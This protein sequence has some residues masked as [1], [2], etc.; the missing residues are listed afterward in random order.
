[1]SSYNY[2]IDNSCNKINYVSFGYDCSPAAT[3]RNLGIR[4]F[5]LPFD[6]VESKLEYI[7]NCIED[8]F[9]NF[10]CNL[11]LN[12]TETRVIDKY[13][14]EFPHDYPF[15]KDFCEEKLGDGVFGEDLQKKIIKN[16]NNYYDIVIKKYKRRIE[17]FN[18]IFNDTKPIIIL[19]RGYSVKNIK[20]F[21]Y[22]LTNKYKKG[23]IY[24]VVSSNEKFKNNMI[25]TCNTEK[26]G[27]WNEDVLWN[28][29]IQE[30][31]ISNK[32]L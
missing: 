22:Y 10:H 20:K 28:K 7:Y 30:I 25:I 27:K 29:A 31:I 26:N 1:M 15:S 16:W 18:H 23:N 21:G 4:D 5:A 13:G 14:F 32:L 24:F 2:E 17:R 9:N 11:K 6:W 12:K 19:C 8:N 3:L